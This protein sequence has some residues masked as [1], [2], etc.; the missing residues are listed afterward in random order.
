MRGPG[1]LRHE[2]SGLCDEVENGGRTEFDACNKSETDPQDSGFWAYHRTVVQLP[3]PGGPSRHPV[4]VGQRTEAIIL[5]EFVRRG[6]RVLTPFGVNH[7]YDLVLDTD[8]GFVR[9]QCKT[10]RLSKGCLIFSTRSIRTSTK[11]TFFRDYGGEIDLFAV[12]CEALGRLYAVPVEVAPKGQCSLRIELTANNQ[13]RNIRWATD[14][15]VPA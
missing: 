9:V 14:F 3:P 2:G 15:E 5:A 11:G 4:D 6:Y 13:A 1:N 7:R 10:G 8:E 12:H